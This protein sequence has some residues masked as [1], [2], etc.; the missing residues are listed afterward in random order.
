MLILV[1]A[2]KGHMRDY[3]EPHAALGPQVEDPPGVGQGVL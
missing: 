3:Y 1:K 2:S